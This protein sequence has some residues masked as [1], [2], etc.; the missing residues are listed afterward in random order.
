MLNE[1]LKCYRKAAH[2]TQQEV[3]DA[4]GIQ[5]SAYAYYEIG[6]STPKLPC[7]KNLAALYN[8]SVDE[9]LNSDAADK[10]AQLDDPDFKTEW[11]TSDKFNDLSDFEKSVVMKVRLMSKDDKNKLMDYLCKD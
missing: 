5:R 9:L 3:A 6:K 10:V 2:L 11:S 8:I 4:I 7:L 1:K